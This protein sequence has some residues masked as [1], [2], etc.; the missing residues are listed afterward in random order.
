MSGSCSIIL[1]HYVSI[2]SLDQSRSILL[3]RDAYKHHYNLL[4]FTFTSFSDSGYCISNLMVNVKPT[5]LKLKRRLVHILMC[6]LES[7]HEE[8][9]EDKAVMLLEQ[10]NYEVKKVLAVLNLDDC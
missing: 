6:L 4:I 2:F 9:S 7:K 1:G 5:N 3:K 8:I 10:H